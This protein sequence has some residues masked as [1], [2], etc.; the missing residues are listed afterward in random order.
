MKS[1]FTEIIDHPR[2][3]EIIEKI[4]NGVPASEIVAWLKV[5]YD[6]NE[7][8]HLIL[9][10][11]LIKD[12]SKSPYMDYHKQFETDIRK[13]SGGERLDKKISSALLN[14][15]TYQERLLELTDEGLDLKK[16][17]LK[18]KIFFDSRM[19]QI[20]DKIQEN[21]DALD[22]K[23]DY[24]L[25]KYTEQYLSLLEKYDK[26]VNNRPDQIIQHNYT[27]EYID[28]RTEVIQDAIRETLEELGSDATLIFF[29]K[30]QE[31]LGSL[32]FKEEGGK[33]VPVLDS[34]YADFSK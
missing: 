28:Q 2:T 4:L 21:P 23:G 10:E 17:I 18:L 30:M 20:F 15:K 31:K 12:F 6:S 27:M 34:S 7:E 29:N 8:G 26:I 14:N 22:S 33:P 11:S 5:N 24:K 3:E 1:K 13:V 16:E 19:E 32:D 9:S 25:L